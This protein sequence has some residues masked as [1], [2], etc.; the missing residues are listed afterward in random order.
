ME[1]SCAVL[2]VKRLASQ[3]EISKAYRKLARLSHPDKGGSTE[4]MATLNKAYE[5]LKKDCLERPRPTTPS[6]VKIAVVRSAIQAKRCCSA[7]ALPVDGAAARRMMEHVVYDTS[8][9][10]LYA[11]GEW[12]SKADDKVAALREFAIISVDETYCLIQGHRRNV[13]DVAIALHATLLDLP[14]EEHLYADLSRRRNSS[15]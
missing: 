3:G 8:S 7:M 15:M 2:G 10:A 14:D 1:E 11:P 9:V 4:T 13:I 6:L 5:C 12:W